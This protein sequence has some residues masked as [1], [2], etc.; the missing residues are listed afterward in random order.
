VFDGYMPGLRV[1]IDCY[2]TR[3]P[4]E[5]LQDVTDPVAL[6]KPAPDSVALNPPFLTAVPT[7]TTVTLN[8][9]SCGGPPEGILYAGGGGTANLI[10][11]YLVFRSTDGV[12]YTQI[13]NLLN[14]ADEFGALSVE[15]LTYTD[16]NPPASTLYYYVQGYDVCQNAEN[17]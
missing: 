5:F 12:S 7:S 9:T 13:A 2:D 16:T 10:A 15:T 14:T 11:G 8:W 4:Q 3:H 6:W 17:G 1:C